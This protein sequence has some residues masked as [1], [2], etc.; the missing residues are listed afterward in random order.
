MRLRLT[1]RGDYAVRAMVA[2]AD[3][4]GSQLTGGQIAQ[5]TDIPISFLPQ[6]MGTL[7]H[8]GL[9][10]GLQGRTGG[11][12]LA[13]PASSISLLNVVEAAEGTS[14]RT[15]CILRGGP[16]RTN[17]TCSVHAAFSAAQ[18]ALLA[19]LAAARLDGVANGHRREVV[20]G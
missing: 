1:K 5:R 10:D 6:V 4:G 15:S 3:A 12:R 2:L 16:C 14:R 9:V 18:D 7:V 8:A 13:Q 17:G 19:E 20:A 11:Y